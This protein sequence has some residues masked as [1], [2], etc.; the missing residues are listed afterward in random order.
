MTD[1]FIKLLLFE[2]FHEITTSVLKHPRLYDVHA[3]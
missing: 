1:V 3:L 2:T